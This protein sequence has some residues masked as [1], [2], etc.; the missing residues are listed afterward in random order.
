MAAAKGGDYKLKD[1]ARCKQMVLMATD[2]AERASKKLKLPFLVYPGLVTCNDHRS[3]RKIMHL[4]PKTKRDSFKLP[5]ISASRL[6]PGEMFADLSVDGKLRLWSHSLWESPVVRYQREWEWE[7]ANK[8]FVAAKKTVHTR[9]AESDINFIKPEREE[10][11]V[12]YE[13]TRGLTQSAPTG[14]LVLFTNLEWPFDDQLF[15]PSSPH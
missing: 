8:L 5:A 14:L 2:L 3:L 12:T 1:E 10:A 4:D 9:L 13:A 15:D 6:E 11:L 7:W